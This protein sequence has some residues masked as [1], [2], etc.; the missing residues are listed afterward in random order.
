M[1]ETVV[2]IGRFQPLHEGH[3]NLIKTALDIG[4]QVVIAIGSHN[5]SRSSKNPFTATE[6]E[7]LLKRTLD[8]SYLKRIHFCKMEDRLND[9]D[10]WAENLKRN[11][12]SFHKTPLIDSKKQI[13]VAGHEKDKFLYETLLPDWGFINA[14]SDKT[15][16]IN[17]TEIRAKYFANHDPSHIIGIPE[18]TVQ[19]LKD[20]K[21]NNSFS[22]FNLAEEHQFVIEYNK[23]WENVPYPVNFVTVDNVVCD[24]EKQKILLIE[25]KDNPGKGTIALPG[26][27]VDKY[28]TVKDAAIREL[29]EETN[30]SASKEELT[31]RILGQDIYDAPSRSMRGRIITHPFLFDVSNMNLSTEAGD[32][33]SKVFWVDFSDLPKMQSNFYSD[34]YEILEGM[35]KKFASIDLNNFKE[36]EAYI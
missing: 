26:G 15:Y 33:A 19:F 3:L 25:R 30:I 24:L 20:F 2:V 22:F 4:E 9:N 36:I 32:D 16:L 6:R 31:P 23:K 7:A 21:Y 1:Y 34:H 28:E 11:V 17:A 10:R 5:I 12:L 14:Y 29:K 13:A 27:F 18:T 35:L 8:P